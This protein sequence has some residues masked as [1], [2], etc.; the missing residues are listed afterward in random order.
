MVH[1]MGWT[2]DEGMGIRGEGT[3]GTFLVF[4]LDFHS[5]PI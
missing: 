1:L 4:F 2:D 3:G 5:F